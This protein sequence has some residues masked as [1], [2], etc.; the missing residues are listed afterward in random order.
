MPHIIV[1][2]SANIE[3]EMALGD[4]LGN[5]HEAAL[6]SGIFPLGGLRTRA[7]ARRDY[8]I[9]DGDRENGFVHLNLRIG[10]GRDP[11]TKRLAGE[12]I[13]QALCDHLGPLQARAPLA[14][15]MDIQEIDPVLTFKRN[16][17]HDYVARRQ[18][19]D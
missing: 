11:E 5:L 10:H 18:Q 16:N 19:E 2:Y 12:A 13:F 9:A 6:A 8:V 7:V 1:E 15:S 3:P 17:L 4:L 14:I